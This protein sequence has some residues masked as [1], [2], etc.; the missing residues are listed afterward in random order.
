MID[1]SEQSL[2]TNIH[3]ICITEEEKENGA[4]KIL[5]E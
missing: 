4:D 2:T 5:E 3:V 1:K